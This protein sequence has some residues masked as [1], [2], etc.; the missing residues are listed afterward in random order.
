MYVEINSFLNQQFHLHRRVL[1]K[2]AQEI[3]LYVAH[4]M[5][6]KCQKVTYSP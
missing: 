2:N 5:I 6:K 1:H 4:A 3:S